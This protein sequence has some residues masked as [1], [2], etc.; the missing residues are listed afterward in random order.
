MIGMTSEFLPFRCGKEHLHSDRS[1]F[2]TSSGAAVELHQSDR[3]A[4]CTSS[5][6]AEVFLHA[7]VHCVYAHSV[8]GGI[9]LKS[10]NLG[11]LCIN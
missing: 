9:Q 7:D 1:A 5:G 3:S 4:F 6:A 2:C 10:D 8:R 11:L